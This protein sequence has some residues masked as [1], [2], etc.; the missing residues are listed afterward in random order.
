MH[1]SVAR[2][3]QVE[4]I[5]MPLIIGTTP[6]SEWNLLTPLLN[7]LGWQQQT[8]DPETWYQNHAKMQGSDTNQYL[9][10]HTRPELAIARAL[11][12]GSSPEKA[13][14]SWQHAAEQL[15]VFY[16]QH[17]KQAVMVE[18]LDASRHSN[19]LLD[20]LKTN[21]AAFQDLANPLPEGLDT[22]SPAQ[23][24]EFSRLIAAQLVAQNAELQ[25][26]LA[27][28]DACSIPLTDN[29]YGPPKVDVAS[30]YQHVHE[31]KNNEQAE[32]TNLKEEN[33]LILDQLFQVQEELEK[34]YLEAKAKKEQLT[35]KEQQFKSTQKKLKAELT[36]TQQLLNK[37]QAE[38]AHKEQSIRALKEKLQLVQKSWTWRLTKPL[39]E[40]AILIRKPSERKLINKQ[41][42][43]INQSGLFDAEWYLD[44]NL[45][46]KEKGANPVEHFVMHGG[47]EG[48]AP[49]PNFNTEYYLKK[50][51]D[52]AESGQNPLIHYLLH[53]KAEGRTATDRTEPGSAV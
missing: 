6:N 1:E 34:Y 37:T 32:L 16:K 3:Q 45:D 41:V 31:Q 39:R 15:L 5:R 36:N 25:P 26:L 27:Q 10:L 22:S 48:R 12:A 33:K 49:G 11:D 23:P 20:W 44:N 35:R 8:Q 50:Y 30:V 24:S 4:V 17:R 42:T 38:L 52:V 51:P 53:G 28:L 13:L 7:H 40:V 47:K 18:V 29:Q 19:T 46:V 9:L 2:N 21:H 14:E 43:L